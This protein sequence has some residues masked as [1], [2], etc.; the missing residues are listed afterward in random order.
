[1]VI[2]AVLVALM[3]TRL[4]WHRLPRTGEIEV[5]EPTTP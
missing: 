1:V 3:G 4:R 2:D 5:A